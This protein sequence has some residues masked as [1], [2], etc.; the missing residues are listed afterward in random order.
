M[1]VAGLTGKK[2]AGILQPG[3]LPWVG[4]FQQM[5]CS[6]VFIL[7]DDVQFDKHGWRNRN[8]IKGPNGPV[9]LTVP[10]LTKGMGRPLVKEIRIN[11]NQGN[12]RKKHLGTIRQ[13]YVKAP[14][15]QPYFSELEELMM[16]ENWESLLELDHALILLMARWLDLQPNLVLSSS[17]GVSHPD[18]T[19][20]L[21]K[22]LQAVEADV[23]YEGAS[24]RDYLDL[25]SFGRH[26]IELVFQDFQPAAYPQ[27][28]EG[29]E[30][31][32]SALDLVLNCGPQSRGYLT[33][34]DQLLY[35]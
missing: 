27:Q 4:F 25:A 2:V 28:Y 8:R 12:W 15:F 16:N 7:Y 14:H 18:A 26:G 24:G 3:Y 6:D 21:V 20:R 33:I 10:V 22:L 1:T 5:L 9:W 23:F 32:L 13:H 19:Q 35:Q 17:L 29:F 34:D 11:G 31:Y 30:P